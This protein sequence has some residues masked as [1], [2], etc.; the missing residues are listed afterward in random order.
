MRLLH[1]R[2]FERLFAS[3]QRTYGAG[4]V[5]ISATN[6][7]KHPRL[8]LAISKKKI[9]RAVERNRTKRVIRDSFR[10][11]ANVLPPLDIIVQASARTTS[12]KSDLTAA[13]VDLLWEKIH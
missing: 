3:G 5:V 1:S 7:L 6:A 9:P 12:R 13:E 2:E 4:L 11:H 8:G 10:R